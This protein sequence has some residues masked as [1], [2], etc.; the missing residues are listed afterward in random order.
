LSKRAI[1]TFLTL[2]VYTGAVEVNRG[3]IETQPGDMEALRGVT[4][5]EWHLLTAEVNGDAWGLTEYI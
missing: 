1:E 3:A 4:R 2:E 5:E